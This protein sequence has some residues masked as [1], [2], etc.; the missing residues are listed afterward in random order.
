MRNSEAN[1]LL[2]EIMDIFNGFLAMWHSYDNEGASCFFSPLIQYAVNAQ[3]GYRHNTFHFDIEECLG[4]VRKLKFFKGD[5]FK[6]PLIHFDL[7]TD[8]VRVPHLVR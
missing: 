6:L 8:V 7:R 1:E 4:K 2:I 5:F 3:L